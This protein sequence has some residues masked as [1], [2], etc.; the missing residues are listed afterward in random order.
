MAWRIV[1]GV[2]LVSGTAWAVPPEPGSPAAEE[3]GR[4]S[5]KERE[6]I[7]RQHDQVG[8]W[9]C[10]EGDFDFVTV[11]AQDGKLRAKAKHPDDKKGIPEGWIDVPNDK[12]VDVRGQHEV[13]DVIAA[14]YYQGRIQCILLGGGY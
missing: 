1:L 3:L 13:P 6:W 9:C 4:Y 14:W 2:V 8:R 10:T 5:P 7:S 12:I 11:D